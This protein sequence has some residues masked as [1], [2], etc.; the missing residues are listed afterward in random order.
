MKRPEREI[1]RPGKSLLIRQKRP[2]D[3]AKETGKSERAS[4]RERAHRKAP[5]TTSTCVH[6]CASVKRDL[7]DLQKRPRRLAKET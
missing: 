4:E 5:D 2:T 1:K 6:V 7:G 3:M